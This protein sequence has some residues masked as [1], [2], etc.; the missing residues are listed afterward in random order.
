MNTKNTCWIAL[1]L[2]LFHICLIFASIED[3]KDR[4]SFDSNDVAISDVTLLLPHTT[5]SKVHYRLEAYNGCFKWF[6]RFS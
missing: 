5:K 3:S 4:K 1:I 2:F 6:E